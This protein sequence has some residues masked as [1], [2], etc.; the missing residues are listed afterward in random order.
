MGQKEQAGLAELKALAAK[1]RQD[2]WSGKSD[3]AHEILK[4]TR[5]KLGSPVS[6]VMKEFIAAPSAE[7]LAAAHP[8]SSRMSVHQALE[9]AETAELFAK[10]ADVMAADVK[11]HHFVGDIIKENYD[12]TKQITRE[13]AEFAQAV[14]RFKEAEEAQGQRP[15][16]TGKI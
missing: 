10:N 3:R 11:S 6:Q 1:P 12:W 8:Y 5:E 13:L 4:M 15:Q 2:R 14:A 9:A 16:A 7:R